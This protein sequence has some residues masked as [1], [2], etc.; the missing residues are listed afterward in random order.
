MK[1]GI[2]QEELED[3]AHL[4]VVCME[5]PRVTVLVPCG[6]MAL[7]KGCCDVL[8]DQKLKSNEVA[9]CPM[10]R[11]AVEYHVEVDE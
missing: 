4:C 10:C 7:C 1:L 11:H 2:N 9:E 5:H 8:I 3:D 6:H